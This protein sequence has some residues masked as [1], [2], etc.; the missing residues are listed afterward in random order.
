MAELSKVAVVHYPFLQAEGVPVLR[1]APLL[2]PGSPTGLMKN[3]EHGALGK[4]VLASSL[5]IL[6]GCWGLLRGQY[7]T[8]NWTGLQRYWLEA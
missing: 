8:V 7:S 4:K 5:K 2:W 3:P 1:N 6:V